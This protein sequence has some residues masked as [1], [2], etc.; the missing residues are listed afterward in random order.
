MERGSATRGI[1]LR[2]ED[3]LADQ[4]MSSSSDSHGHCVFEGGGRNFIAQEC[5]GHDVDSNAEELAQ[6]FGEPGHA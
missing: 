5:C 6:L 2:N 4:P 1:D 3:L